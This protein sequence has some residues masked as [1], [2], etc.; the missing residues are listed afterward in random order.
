MVFRAT[1]LLQSHS[2]TPELLPDPRR[3]MSAPSVSYF[4][5]FQCELLVFRPP[6][7]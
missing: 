7:K 5:D 1:P 3:G 2:R 6:L 4:T